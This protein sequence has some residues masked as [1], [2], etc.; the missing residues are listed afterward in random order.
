MASSVV[1]LPGM[2]GGELPVSQFFRALFFEEVLRVCQAFAMELTPMVELLAEAGWG[3]AGS[4]AGWDRYLKTKYDATIP[5]PVLEE[6]T[7]AEGRNEWEIGS[8]KQAR[9]FVKHSRSSTSELRWNKTAISHHLCLFLGLLG[10]Y[11][12]AQLGET[13]RRRINLLSREALGIPEKFGLPL[14]Y[15]ARYGAPR[16]RYYAAKT[17]PNINLS[18]LPGVRNEHP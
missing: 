17:W 16:V 15:L 7:Q 14:D 9:A 11:A 4:D 1:V 10:E 3:F 6:F 5:V 12:V 2:E 8:W 18:R 13:Y